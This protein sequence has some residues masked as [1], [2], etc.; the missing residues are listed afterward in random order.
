MYA[1]LHLKVETNHLDPPATL[2]KAVRWDA[3]L[4][5]QHSS[6]S[7]RDLQT[8]GYVRCSSQRAWEMAD[9]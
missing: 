1:Q 4:L 5:L 6:Y 9:T 2:T 7:S 8:A 3:Q